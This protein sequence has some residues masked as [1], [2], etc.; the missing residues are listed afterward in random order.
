MMKEER[1]AITA[2]ARKQNGKY[3]DAKINFASLIPF[4]ITEFQKSQKI[5]VSEYFIYQSTLLIKIEPTGSTIVFI[6]KFSF[7]A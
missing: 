7:A 5:W 4:Q 3:R 2:S 6:S 1:A